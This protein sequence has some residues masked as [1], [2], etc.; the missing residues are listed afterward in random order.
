MWFMII[1]GFL[2]VASIIASIKWE[3][4]TEWET[5]SVFFLVFLILSGIIAGLSR[6]GTFCTVNNLIV[7]YDATYQNYEIIAEKT[8]TLILSIPHSTLVDP[9]SWAQSKEASERWKETRDSVR[10]YNR[11]LISL[12]RFRATPI[13][14]GMV[15]NIPE[16]LKLIK[17]QQ[18][19]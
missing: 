7:F 10:A 18:V 13:C 5:V 2:T 19:K 15:S 6:V 9:T 3:C 4:S 17:F 14:R 1:F 16:R 8:E 11:R 12:R